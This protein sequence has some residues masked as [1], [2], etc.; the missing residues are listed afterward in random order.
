VTNVV[1]ELSIGK[2]FEFEHVGEVALKGFP[3]PVLIARVVA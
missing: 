2:N 1:K 3:D